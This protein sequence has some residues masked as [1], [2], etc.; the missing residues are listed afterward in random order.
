M[1]FNDL[2]FQVENSNGIY[3]IAHNYN[4]AMCNFVI[5]EVLERI[6]NKN[7]YVIPEFADYDET[8]S[9]SI[10]I[11]D[12]D[13]VNMQKGNNDYDTKI[14]YSHKLRDFCMKNQ[15]SI[16]IKKQL[17]V[18]IGGSPIKTSQVPTTLAYSANFIA[19]IT[20][21]NIY[22]QKCRFDFNR[23]INL[24]AYLREKRIDSIFKD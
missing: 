4:L 8:I 10:L 7:V 17:S 20:D 11:L 5:N 18:M 1:I 22:L 16:I 15:N 23:T 2:A 21:N 14:N 6:E 13:C 9:D 3:V 19:T 24:K 12:I